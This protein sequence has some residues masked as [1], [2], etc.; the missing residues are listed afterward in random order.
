VAEQ[1]TQD[2]CINGAAAHLAKPGDIIII[3][4]FIWL[5]EAECKDFK[6][7]VVFVNSKNQI[8]ETKNTETKLKAVQ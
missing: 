4:R 5:N 6:P 1:D 3:A 7:K 2:I 8:K